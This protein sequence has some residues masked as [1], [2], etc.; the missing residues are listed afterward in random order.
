M[1][2]R[3]FRIALLTALVFTI[4]ASAL[5]P[6]YGQKLSAR[7]RRALEKRA[8]QFHENYLTIDTH[9]DAALNINNPNRKTRMI[10]GQITFPLMEAGGLDAAVFAVFVGQKKRDQAS[11]DSAKRYVHWN[12]QKFREYV[13][14]YPGVSIAY[15]SDDLIRNKKNG[16]KSV[17]IAERIFVFSAC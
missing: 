16:I 11:L 10:K 6:V 3:K 1:Y 9:N 5:T 14:N 2:K 17:M 7:E 12:I 13:E 4:V 15:N 8:D